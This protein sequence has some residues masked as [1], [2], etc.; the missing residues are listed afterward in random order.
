MDINVLSSMHVCLGKANNGKS[1]VDQLLFM[2]DKQEVKLLL[3]CSLTGFESI[4]GLISPFRI[5]IFQH[6]TTLFRADQF[7][8][9]QHVLNMSPVL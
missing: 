5:V 8:S 4:Q 3:V 1:E 7:V 9:V 2:L 6:L